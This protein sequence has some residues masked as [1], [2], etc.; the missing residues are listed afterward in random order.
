MEICP[1][2]F[3]ISIRASWNISTDWKYEKFQKIILPL[4]KSF[5]WILSSSD[6]TGQKKTVPGADLVTFTEE[7]FNGKYHF[8]KIFLKLK[9]SNEVY[10]RSPLITP[11]TWSRDLYIFWLQSY[12]CVLLMTPVNLIND[13]TYQLHL[14]TGLTAYSFKFIKFQEI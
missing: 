9:F 2:Y 12:I 11:V 8:L 14:S 3:M 1:D 4:W 6:F 13:V 5:P 7:I 10:L